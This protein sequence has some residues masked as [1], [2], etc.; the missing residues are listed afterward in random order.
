MKVREDK[1]QKIKSLLIEFLYWI[2]SVSI[3]FVAAQH[4]HMWTSTGDPAGT[5]IGFLN[6]KK[7]GNLIEEWALR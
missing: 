1:D 2:W 5:Y 7:I 3:T 6:G 4:R